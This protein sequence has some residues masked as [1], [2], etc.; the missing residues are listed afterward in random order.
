[1]S[2]NLD[3]DEITGFL[4]ALREAV[5]ASLRDLKRFEQAEAAALPPTGRLAFESGV[6][7]LRGYVRWAERARREIQRR[8]RSKGGDA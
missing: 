8:K 5:R 6:E 3:R 7:G 1:M 4:V 2:G